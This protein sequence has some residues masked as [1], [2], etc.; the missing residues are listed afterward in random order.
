MTT[1]D[2]NGARL[3]DEQGHPIGTVKD[4][5]PDPLSGDSKWMVVRVGRLRGDH[6][7]PVEGSYHSVDDAVVSPYSADDVK[8]APKAKGDHV[9][10]PDVEQMLMTHFHLTSA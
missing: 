7:V 3:V 8:A 5:I 6:Y 10:T 9:V 2:Y 4:V 1:S